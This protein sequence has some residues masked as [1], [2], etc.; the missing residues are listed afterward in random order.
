MSMLQFLTGYDD[1]QLKKLTGNIKKSF[2]D[3]CNTLK[4]IKK[5]QIKELGGK[6]SRC[7]MRLIARC[8]EYSP[9]MRLDMED[10]IA[11]FACP[12]E[13]F[14]AIIDSLSK[15]KE[16]IYTQEIHKLIEQSKTLPSIFK[17]EGIPREMTPKNVIPREEFPSVSSPKKE[18][19]KEV[20]YN[21]LLYTSPSPRD[22][23]TS[24]MPS[25]A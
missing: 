13:E 23:S 24:R 1:I 6:A 9:C 7:I 21:C 8:L 16:N 2:V 15:E 4:N 5:I 12:N 18:I 14:S 25:S 3:C 19:T 22:L 17:Q 20:F 10:V 11:C